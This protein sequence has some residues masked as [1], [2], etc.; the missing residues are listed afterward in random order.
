MSHRRNLYDSPT[1]ETLDR[2]IGEFSR[3]APVGLHKGQGD[4]LRLNM[5]GGVSAEQVLERAF[6][7]KAGVYA[8]QV[9]EVAKHPPIDQWVLWGSLTWA[10]GNVVV[11]VHPIPLPQAL[12]IV[13]GNEALR[14]RIAEGTPA[15]HVTAVLTA[16]GVG[17]AVRSLPVALGT[18]ADELIRRAISGEG[19][20]PL[21]VGAGAHAPPE[22]SAEEAL[23]AD[24]IKAAAAPLRDALRD[25]E[26]LAAGD[27]S[28]AADAVV[29]H[30]DARDASVAPRV[31]LLTRAEAAPLLANV[32][33]PDLASAPLGPGESLL[34][35]TTVL[36]RALLIAHPDSG[37]RVAPA[38]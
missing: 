38:G 27:P 23:E 21:A 31:D 26:G 29:L 25:R 7:Q 18:D 10:G 24:A 2:V 28:F 16:P 37:V 5:N 30:L 19:E 17:T 15:G 12:Q 35:V 22:E 14:R 1:K 20:A 32:A 4:V 36:R 34:L 11:V 8:L 6:D 33:R 3:S 13:A 9:A